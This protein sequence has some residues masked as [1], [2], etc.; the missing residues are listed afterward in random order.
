MGNI[1]GNI[2]TGFSYSLTML[3]M[4]FSIL[5]VLLGIVIG[6]IPGVGPTMVIAMLLPVTYVMEPAN[7]MLFMMGIFVGG[8]FGGSISSIMLNIPGHA[9]AVVTCWDGNKLAAKGEAKRALSAALMAS[10]FG[11][12]LSALALLFCSPLLAKVSLAFGPQEYFAIGLL[13]M[14]LVS[15]LESGG[16][17]AKGCVTAG[18]GLLMGLIGYAPQTAFPRF[19]FANVELTSGLQLVPVLVGMFCLPEA[20]LMAKN[21]INKN[22]RTLETAQL[23]L[24]LRDLKHYFSDFIAHIWLLIKCGVMSVIIGVLPG[25]GG[26]IATFISYAEAR[27]AS[28]HPETFGQGEVAGVL[29]AEVANNGASCSSLV[30]LLTMGIPGSATAAVFFGT[31]TLHGISPGPLLFTRNADTVYTL[32]T[33]TVIQQA[34]L[35]ILGVLLIP[36]LSKVSKIP[37]AVLV[38]LI[39]LFSFV[40][41]YGCRNNMFD[42]YVMLACGFL[43]YLL[44]RS[45]FPLGPL[46]LGVVLGP[47]IET[48]YKTAM[49]ISNGSAAILFDGMIP[50]LI[51]AAILYMLF[52]PVI[53]KKVKRKKALTAG[54]ENR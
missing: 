46:I 50:W 16:S 18:L 13:G 28:A 22:R 19:T 3:P 49:A 29:A 53:K 15:Y 38:P 48:N 23:F 1:F 20:Y 30:P 47:I 54:G 42:V 11:G 40:G 52:A 17:T 41:S 8:M 14:V 32:L 39:V 10:V 51:Y 31:L 26:T 34:F 9:S 35:L 5:G 36:L 7:G 2:L 24:S 33:G 25:A 6:A 45:G 37:A 12:L 4:L 21:S 27:R 43:G 44:R